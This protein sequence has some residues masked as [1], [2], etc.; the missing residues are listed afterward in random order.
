M[1]AT[2][3]GFTEDAKGS[4]NQIVQSSIARKRIIYPLLKIIAYYVNTQIIPEFGFEGIKYKYKIF[5]VD[6]ET[7]KWGLYKLRTESGLKTINEER[8][9]EGLDPV[10]VVGMGV[11]CSYVTLQSNETVSKEMSKEMLQEAF[12]TYKERVNDGKVD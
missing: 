4:A 5:D 9:A 3:L 2:E 10:D 8:N 11:A 7:K 1:T 6:D 12:N